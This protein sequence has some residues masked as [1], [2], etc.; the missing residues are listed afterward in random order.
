MRINHL[1]KLY[2]T[3]VA[4]SVLLGSNPNI[5]KY[6]LIIAALS[7]KPSHVAKTPLTEYTKVVIKREL[8]YVVESKYER[9]I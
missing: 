6:K 9:E 7:Y 4:R 2:S 1:N 3:H 8:G 5:P